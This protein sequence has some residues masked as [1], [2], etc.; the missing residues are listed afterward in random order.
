MRHP[1][2]RKLRSYRLAH[3]LPSSGP[4]VAGRITDVAVSSKSSAS[5]CVW[6]PAVT[7]PA[8]A[9]CTMVPQ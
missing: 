8:E 1:K 7:R 9:G 4:I 6:S 2:W 3:L 5:A